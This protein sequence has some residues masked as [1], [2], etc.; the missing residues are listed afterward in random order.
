MTP[1]DEDGSQE[2]E[3]DGG[4]GTFDGG[5]KWY[6]KSVSGSVAPN[7]MLEQVGHEISTNSNSFLYPGLQLNQVRH[8]GNHDPQRQH[9]RY[10]AG[11]KVNVPVSGIGDDTPESP[12]LQAGEPSAAENLQSLISDCGLTENKLQEL[13]QELPEKHDT[14]QLI[15]YYFR[16]M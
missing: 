6:G 2:E 14:D 3:N 7:A 1:P 10:D 16:N 4:V 9:P 15:D 8:N 13:V 12:L 11:L 5:G